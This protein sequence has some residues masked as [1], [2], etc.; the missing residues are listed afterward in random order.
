MR[1]CHCYNKKAC[2]CNVMHETIDGAFISLKCPLKKMTGKNYFYHQYVESQFHS[3]YLF[4][5]YQVLKRL[6]MEAR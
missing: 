1:Y 6:E 3:G 5:I 4:G 2:S